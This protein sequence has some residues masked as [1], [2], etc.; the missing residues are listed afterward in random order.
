MKQLGDALRRGRKA[1]GSKNSAGSGEHGVQTFSPNLYALKG[2]RERTCNCCNGDGR[3]QVA[4]PHVVTRQGSSRVAGFD[5]NT[6]SMIFP[7]LT[8]L[9]GIS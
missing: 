8:P 7:V 4:P 5:M 1:S 2:E 6:I 3:P 9:A